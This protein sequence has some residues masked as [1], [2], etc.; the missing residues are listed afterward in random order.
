M[1][2]KTSTPARLAE[3]FAAVGFQIDEEDMKKVGEL[4]CNYRGQDSK[5]RE[6][7]DFYPLF[8]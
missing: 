6:F 2:P 7:A 3:N 4:D 8:D 5:V 1:I